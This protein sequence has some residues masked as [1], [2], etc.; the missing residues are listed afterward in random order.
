ME[1]SKIFLLSP[2]KCYLEVEIKLFKNNNMVILKN[3][4]CMEN[5][6]EMILL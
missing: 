4:L 5:I 6:S 2:I 1:V 3:T